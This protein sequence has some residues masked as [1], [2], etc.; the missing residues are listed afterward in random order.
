MKTLLVFLVYLATP[1]VAIADCVFGAKSKTSYVVLDTKTVLLNG[2]YGSDII[3]QTY[4][5]INQSSSLVVLKDDFCSYEDAVLY[6]DGE[7]AD[8]AQVTKVN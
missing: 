1:S 2:G 3:I 8:A 6:V 4:S 5:F 7:V